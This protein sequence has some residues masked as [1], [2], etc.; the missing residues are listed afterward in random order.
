MKIIYLIPATF[1]M[2]SMFIL[3]LVVGYKFL[4]KNKEDRKDGNN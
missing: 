3:Y 1:I 4:T 2:L